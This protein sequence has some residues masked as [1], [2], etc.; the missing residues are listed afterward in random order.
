MLKNIARITTCVL[1][2]FTLVLT[3][4]F[5]GGTALFSNAGVAVALTPA[6]KAAQKAAR[7]K[8]RKGI[9]E[10]KIVRQVPGKSRRRPGMPTGLPGRP[11]LLILLMC[12]RPTRLPGMQKTKDLCPHPKVSQTSPTSKQAKLVSSSYRWK[13]GSRTCHR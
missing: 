3:Q 11:T 7:K 4:G 10:K 9:K 6:E 2:A 1:V 5:L 8:L 13:T 12:P